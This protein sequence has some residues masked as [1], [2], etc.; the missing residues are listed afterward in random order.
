[1]ARYLLTRVFLFVCLLCVYSVALS[2]PRDVV[3]SKIAE[4]TTISKQKTKSIIPS[5]K[6]IYCRIDG[7]G[8]WG[9]VWVV[10][11]DVYATAFH[12][13]QNSDMCLIDDEPATILQSEPDKDFALV[14]SNTGD[15]VP[16]KYSCADFQPGK[17]YFG[18]GYPPPRG[19]TIT[20]LVATNTFFTPYPEDIDMQS[21]LGSRVMWGPIY[22]GMSGGP[23]VDINGT[24]IGINSATSAPTPFSE[25]QPLS[26]TSLC[27]GSK[28]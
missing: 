10:R 9:T 20:H 11:K 6:E 7:K 18:I 8:Y 16:L 22:H 4:P 27:K 21:L 2:Q 3:V 12:V 1:M 17:H 15:M 5:V 13:V 26:A 28:S 24:V 14:S 23:V 19:L 25:S